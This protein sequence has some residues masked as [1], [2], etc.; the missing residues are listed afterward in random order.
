MLIQRFSLERAAL[1][2]DADQRAGLRRFSSIG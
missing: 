1:A 2:K